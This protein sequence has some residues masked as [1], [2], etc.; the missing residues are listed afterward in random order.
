VVKKHFFKIFSAVFIVGFLSVS[1]LVFT[2]PAAADTVRSASLVEVNVHVAPDPNAGGGSNGGGS[3]NNSGGS[4]GG[5]N[6]AG[7]NVGMPGVGSNNDSAGANNSGVPNAG[8]FEWL[9]ES[10]VVGDKKIANFDFLIALGAVIIIAV[11]W[12]IIFHWLEMHRHLGRPRTRKNRRDKR[13]KKALDDPMTEIIDLEDMK[14]TIRRFKRKKNAVRTLPFVAGF[15][16]VG[17]GLYVLAPSYA[18]SPIETPTT[19]Q[20]DVATE[21]VCL[22]SSVAKIA[23]DLTENAADPSTS[24]SATT[25]LTLKTAASVSGYKISAITTADSAG[26]VV[27]EAKGGDL[28]DRTILPTQPAP[29]DNTGAL[30]VASSSSA[31]AA[32][33]DTRALEFTAT[34]PSNLALG[35]YAVKVVYLVEAEFT[36]PVYVPT[37]GT[38]MQDLTSDQCRNMSTFTGTNTAVLAHLVDNRNGYYYWVGKLADGKCWM[39]ENL[40]LDG[41]SVIAKNGSSYVLDSS[42]TNLPSGNILT[43][44]A[45]AATGAAIGIL[46]S[47][48]ASDATN[49]DKLD[50]AN[51]GS[52]DPS[53]YHAASSPVNNS[54][55]AD[56]GY[57]YNWCAAM[58]GQSAACPDENT[59]PTATY[60]DICPKGWHMPTGGNNGTS[61]FR[62]LGSH[63]PGGSNSDRFSLT[64]STHPWLSSAT[65]PFRGV[66]AGGFD[67]EPYDQGI[68]GEIWSST[69]DFVDSHSA[70]ELY[71]GQTYVHPG[72]NGDY[73][74]YGDAIRC[75]LS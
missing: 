43:P 9:R 12:Y 6:N 20:C 68:G 34:V 61:E 27:L 42:N 54:N 48:T 29:D 58:G 32:T 55:T 56:Y 31:A 5:N 36:P 16:F 60:G 15:L 2:R 64:P 24:A 65:S 26:A 62:A 14:S 37:A 50:V 53:T 75:T 44:S 74:N 72:T 28:A 38:A 35:D 3:G 1:G 22:S 30:V 17:A 39:L 57:L 73:R 11:I 47:A 10:T 45:T 23:I 33:G 40:Q 25:D 59:Y 18:T 71:F 69:L 46:P 21:T 63:L 49:Y 67:S 70:F 66:F 19:A 4:S 41:A 8:A 52:N 13:L 51:P 7:G